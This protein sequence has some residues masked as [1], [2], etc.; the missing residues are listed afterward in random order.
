MKNRLEEAPRF[1]EPPLSLVRLISEAVWDFA[2]ENKDWE[3]HIRYHDEP[4]WVLRRER[5]GEVE[6]IQL[7]FFVLWQGMGLY[8]IPD[9]SGLAEKGR[10]QFRKDNQTFIAYQELLI[11]GSADVKRILKEVARKL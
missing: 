10:I 4:V 1:V 11:Y 9:R 8:V 2:Q 7:A 6:R 5:E 3:P